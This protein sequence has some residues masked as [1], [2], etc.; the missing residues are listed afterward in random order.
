MMATFKVKG[1]SSE[2]VQNMVVNSLYRLVYFI[3][4]LIGIGET[5]LTVGFA[6]WRKFFIFNA[7]HTY[8]VQEDD[9]RLMTHKM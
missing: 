5:S 2:S 9:L 3:T 6:T 7:T 8:S 4:V 1:L